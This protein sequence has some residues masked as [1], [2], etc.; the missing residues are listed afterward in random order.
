MACKKFHENKFVI[1]MFG[2]V[3]IIMAIRYWM[4]YENKKRQRRQIR[5]R[6]N[7]VGRWKEQRVRKLRVQRLLKE[8]SSSTS[9][10]M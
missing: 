3:E 6:G 4:L 5:M 7:A 2:L 8:S 10:G 9:A 1:K